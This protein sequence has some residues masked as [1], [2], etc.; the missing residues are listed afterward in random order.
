MSD[1]ISQKA[2]RL[3]R[4]PK[5]ERPKD[6]FAKMPK[7]STEFIPLYKQA[8]FR[9]MV[10]RMEKGERLYKGRVRHMGLDPDE[11]VVCDH[12][13]CKHRESFHSLEI[14]TTSGHIRKSDVYIFLKNSKGISVIGA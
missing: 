10:D 9:K 14:P 1:S 12:S 7:S 3:A 6:L 2:F 13:N 4:T 11:K 5:S 8:W